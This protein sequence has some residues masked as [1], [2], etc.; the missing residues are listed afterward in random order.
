MRGGRGWNVHGFDLDIVTRMLLGGFSQA[1][2][3]DGDWRGR[4]GGGGIIKRGGFESFCVCD[5]LKRRRKG[6]WWWLALSLG[7]VGD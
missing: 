5:D 6:V 2:K 4:G 3:I 7:A 1:M